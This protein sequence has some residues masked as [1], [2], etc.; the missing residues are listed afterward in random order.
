VFELAGILEFLD[1]DVQEAVE[2]IIWA[3]VVRER[4]A[5]KLARSM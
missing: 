4:V 3:V 5:V 1:A 2:A